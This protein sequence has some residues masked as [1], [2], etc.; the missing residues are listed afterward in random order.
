MQKNADISKIK[1]VLVLKGAFSEATQVC[2]P[3]N[4]ILNSIIIETNFRQGRRVVFLPPL[5]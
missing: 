1:G 5:P 4:Q 2:V 3:T